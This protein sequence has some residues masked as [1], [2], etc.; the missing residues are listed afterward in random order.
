[1]PEPGLLVYCMALRRNFRIIFAAILMATRSPH[2]RI[3]FMGVA[4]HSLGQLSAISRHS[5]KTC[6]IV[7]SCSPQRRQAVVA[8][9]PSSAQSVR[10]SVCF[11]LAR[12]ICTAS[13]LGRPCKKSRALQAS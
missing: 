7:S 10:R 13:L 12:K 2:Q 3:S 9:H 6:V 4:G 1:M 11:A 5:D 8:D